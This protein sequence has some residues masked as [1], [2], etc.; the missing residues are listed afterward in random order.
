MNRISL[1]LLALA[2]LAAAAWAQDE[3]AVVD[4]TF[5][6]EEGTV[7]R[8]RGQLPAI[9]MPGGKE[10]AEALPHDDRVPLGYGWQTVRAWKEGDL[11]PRP[12][13]GEGFVRTEFFDLRYSRSVPPLAAKAFVEYGDFVHFAIKDRLG[14]TVEEP[15]LLAV[16]LDGKS[17]TRRYGL[18]WWIPGDVR[19]DT[20]VVQ[21]ISAITSRGIAM[22]TLTR[23]YV[24]WQLRQR[25]GDRLPYWFL[26]G[27][28]AHLGGEGWILEDQVNALV[29]EYEIE[30][31]QQTMIRD[32]EIFRDSALMLEELESPGSLEEERC[33]SR[34]AFWRAYKLA[35][36]ILIREGQA[37]FGKLVAAMAADPA[38]GFD[39]AARQTY[40]KGV[41]ALVAEHAPW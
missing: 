28:G 15:A 1:A 40:G 6:S 26:Y 23:I 25:T 14:W 33:R 3:P 9:D 19:G 30:I 20:M 31:D 11:R 35:E 39:E 36:N 2:C 4:T 41:D 8:V 32:L 12:E 5:V 21:P 13:E 27:A 37:A 38:L 10:R 17:Y 22:E 7:L 24:E 34:L 18:P 16:P 29:E